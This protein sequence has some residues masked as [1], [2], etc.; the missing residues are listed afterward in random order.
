M[1]RGSD[2][3]GDDVMGME[4]HAHMTPADDKQPVY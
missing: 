3:A 1:L 2:P 4:A